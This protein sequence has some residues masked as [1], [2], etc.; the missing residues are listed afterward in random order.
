MKLLRRLRN[1]AA[2][3]AVAAILVSVFAIGTTS[4][5]PPHCPLVCM[6]VPFYP[7]YVCWHQC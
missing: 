6:D 1:V 2:V 7:Y 5:R 4:A 3:F